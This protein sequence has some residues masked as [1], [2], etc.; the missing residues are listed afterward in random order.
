M[1]RFIETR[2]LGAGVQVPNLTPWR[3]SITGDMT[4]AL[5]FNKPN[6]EVPTLPQ[7]NVTQCST[8]QFPVPEPQVMPVPP[9]KERP[10]AGTGKG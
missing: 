4:S 1:L 9:D 6:V 8:V 10:R 2:Y 5:N 3:R 7:T